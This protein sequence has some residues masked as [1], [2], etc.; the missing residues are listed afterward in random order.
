[1]YV[2]CLGRAD[3]L[4]STFEINT[5]QPPSP[6]RTAEKCKCLVKYKDD[7]LTDKKSWTQYPCQNLSAVLNDPRR[8]ARETDFFTRLWGE[9]FV[10]Q[11]VVPLTLLPNTH[12][13]YFVDHYKKFQIVSE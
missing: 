5:Q 2:L 9:G 6:T 7:D 3:N 12:R 11:E 10:P 4:Q 13:C 1:M 8:S